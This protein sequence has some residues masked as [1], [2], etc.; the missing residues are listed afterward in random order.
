MN[1]AT[2]KITKLNYTFEECPW[3]TTQLANY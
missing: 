3:I 2:G 1:A